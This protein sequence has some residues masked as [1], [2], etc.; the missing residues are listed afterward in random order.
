MRIP[1]LELIEGWS[2]DY[3][4]GRIVITC[5]SNGIAIIFHAPSEEGN[6]PKLIFIENNEKFC[7]RTNSDGD[8]GDYI[9]N[10][11]KEKLN[12]RDN[13]CFGI[14]YEKL[15]DE[16]FDAKSKYG[17]CCRKLMYKLDEITKQKGACL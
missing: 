5:L 4:Y 7:V 17:D 16:D 11:L 3:C 1:N 2:I 12:I 9:L 8:L 13:E 15:R 14:P 6:G 10:Y